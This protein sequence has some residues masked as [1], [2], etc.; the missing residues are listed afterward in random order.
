[1]NRKEIMSDCPE[2]FEDIL[3]EVLDYLEC[4]FS[5]I[6]VLLTIDDISK[7]HQIEDA[8]DLAEEIGTDLY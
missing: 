7:L 8:R 4:K 1:M 2:D 3:K 5:D 6:Q